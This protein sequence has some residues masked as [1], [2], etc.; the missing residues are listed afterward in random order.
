MPTPIDLIDQ[1]ALIDRGED[2][3]TCGCGRWESH[4]AIYSPAGFERMKSSWLA[5]IQRERDAVRGRDEV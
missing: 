4:A 3:F 2:V 5:H 1:H